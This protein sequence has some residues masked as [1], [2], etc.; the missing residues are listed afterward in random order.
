MGHRPL[1]IPLDP[2][3]KG[4]LPTV[5]S[6]GKDDDTQPCPGFEFYRDT[7]QSFVNGSPF[8]GGSRGMFFGKATGANVLNGE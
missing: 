4:E 5:A 3:S 7:T 8:E 1:Y 2:P 6:I